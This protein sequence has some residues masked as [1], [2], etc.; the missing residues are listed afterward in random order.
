MKACDTESS[1][2]A[3]VVRVSPAHGPAYRNKAELLLRP[4]HLPIAS[5]LI[6][7][8]DRAQLPCYKSLRTVQEVVV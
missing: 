6:I 3:H 8:L 1:G 5:G 2:T 7:V 4:I